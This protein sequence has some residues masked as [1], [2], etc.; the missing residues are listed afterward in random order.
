MFE[1]IQQFIFQIVLFYIA[2]ILILYLIT[3]ITNK[4][5]Y[6]IIYMGLSMIIL[7]LIV[8]YNRMSLYFQKE[9][10]KLKEENSA[11]KPSDN[12]ICDDWSSEECK[13]K[14]KELSKKKDTEK[15]ESGKKKD[16]EIQN[17]DMAIIQ[18]EPVVE[19]Q[20]V[21][22]SNP[23]LLKEN[24]E[25]ADTIKKQ[26]E[27]IRKYIDNYN[28]NKRPIDELEEARDNDAPWMDH[29]NDKGNKLYQAL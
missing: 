22:S 24:I 14:I 26:E 19:P 21:E 4:N 18:T 16:T 5:I 27:I 23:K 28:K 20:P 7:F 1:D 29:D 11:D 12:K 13:E 25:D 17:N 2:Y 9:K 15:K 6:L 8:F 10:D 3:T